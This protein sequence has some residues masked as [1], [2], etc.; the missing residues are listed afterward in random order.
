M[1]EKGVIDQQSGKR[2]YPYDNKTVFENYIKKNKLNKIINNENNNFKTKTKSKPSYSNY[3][4]TFNQI[5]IKDINQVSYLQKK[6]TFMF[7][8]PVQEE[9]IS[10]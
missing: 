2:L 1:K 8:Y 4:D 9:V 5:K 3:D 10:L 6:L 7:L